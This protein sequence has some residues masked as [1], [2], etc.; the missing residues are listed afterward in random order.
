[1][2]DEAPPDGEARR[3]DESGFEDDGS[4]VDV[5]QSTWWNYRWAW[6]IA[7]ALVLA[8]AA[9]LAVWLSVGSRYQAEAWL[10][11]ENHRPFI[12]FPGMGDQKFSRTQVELIRSPVVLGEVVKRPEIAMLTE[13]KAQ[14]TPVEWLE[15]QVHVE[16]VND[17]EIYRIEYEGPNPTAAQLIVNA[18]MDTYVKFQQAKTDKTTQQIIDLLERQKEQRISELERLQKNV[19]E[20]TR[21]ATGQ[22]P[23]FVDPKRPFDPPPSPIPMLRDKLAAVEIEREVLE[24]RLQTKR[25]DRRREESRAG[26]DDRRSDRGESQPARPGR[27]AWRLPARNSRE[28]SAPPPTR[29]RIPTSDYCAIKPRSSNDPSPS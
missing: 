16:A 24:A 1:M 15:E 13:I 28:S 9:P 27:S 18:V 25:E 20:M 21:Q 4:A 29:R 26:G 10:T 7:A 5:R 19:R 22:D 6:S 12:A 2:N 11:I 14:E 17:S 8:A 23:G 3:D